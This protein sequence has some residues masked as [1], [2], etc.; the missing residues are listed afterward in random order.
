MRLWYKSTVKESDF[1]ARSKTPSFVIDIPLIVNSA[2]ES[3]LLSRFQAGRQLY[4]ACLNEAMIRMELMRQSEL[5]QSARKLPKGKART[6][7][8]SEIR[9]AI[10]RQL[11]WL[12]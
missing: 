12:M 3:E 6:T 10:L 2:A 9:N 4:N 5:Y 7:A 8:F 11:P 1:M